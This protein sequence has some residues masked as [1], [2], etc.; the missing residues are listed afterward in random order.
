VSIAPAD[1]GNDGGGGGWYDGCGG[2]DDGGGSSGESDI[3]STDRP[4]DRPT[5]QAHHPT[6]TGE[7]L[8]SKS[9]EGRIECS[10][11]AP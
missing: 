4:T 1:G 11:N 10:S 7:K 2:D 5:D 8:V 6:Q 9:L 3:D